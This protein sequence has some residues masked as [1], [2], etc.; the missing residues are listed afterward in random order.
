[1][2]DKKTGSDIEF[3]KLTPAQQEAYLARGKYKNPELLDQGNAPKGAP[4]G[5]VAADDDSVGDPERPAADEAD[6]KPK[7]ARKRTT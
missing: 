2:S 7:T 5:P 4:T 3:D 1:M 6:D